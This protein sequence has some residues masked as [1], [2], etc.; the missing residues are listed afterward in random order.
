[1]QTWFFLLMAISK[2]SSNQM[3][4]KIGWTAM[5]RMFN[6]GNVLELVCQ[7]DPD[8]KIRCTI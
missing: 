6:L 5:T 3:D 1:M 8:E 4:D 7:C 2:K